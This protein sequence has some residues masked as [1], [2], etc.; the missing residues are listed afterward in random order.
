MSG[1]ASYVNWRRQIDHVDP[2]G[3]YETAVFT[4]ARIVGMVFE[5]YGPYQFLNTVPMD[6]APGV[7]RP[8]VVLRVELFGKYTTPDFRKTEETGY[9]AG[10]LDDELA[11]VL[12]LCLGIR[13]LAGDRTR[14]F[15]SQDLRGLPCGN[16]NRPDPVMP[17]FRRGGVIPSAVRK[18]NLDALE[19]FKDFVGLDA[20]AA[21]AVIRSARLFQHA[22]WVAESDQNLAWIML[23]SAIETAA[24]FWRAA[25]D[26]AIDRLVAWRPKLA[27]RLV[28]VGGDAFMAEVADVIAP[29]TGATKKFL[30]FL[31]TFSPPAP[32]KRPPEAFQIDWSAKGLKST[33]NKVYSFSCAARWHSVSITNGLAA[34]SSGGH[35]CRETDWFSR[36]RCAY[37]DRGG[38]ASS[39]EHI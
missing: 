39:T 14:Q 13:A 16:R 18:H 22:L 20:D 24:N 2:Q 26:A 38:F 17:P 6:D 27:A 31:L 21:S 1:P 28:D 29:V 19:P 4:D 34:N 23:S 5:G 15:G 8:A 10:W 32:P 33:L 30:D 35:I 25:E 37:L 3:G 11:A 12:S 9:H 7:A 36:D